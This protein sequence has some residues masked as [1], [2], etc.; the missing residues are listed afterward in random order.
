MLLDSEGDGANTP[1][2]SAILGLHKQLKEN[3]LQGLDR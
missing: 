2:V 1:I 3:R